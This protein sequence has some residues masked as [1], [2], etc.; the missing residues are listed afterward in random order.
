MNLN[1]TFFITF[2]LNKAKTNKHGLTPIW[3]RITVNSKRAECS[4]QKFVHAKHW[5]MEHNRVRTTCSD[6]TSINDYLDL[7][8]SEILRHYNILLTTQDVVTADDVKNSYKGIKETKK[9]FF[10]LFDQYLQHLVD[11]KE[12]NDLSEGRYKRFQVLLN[13]C[14]GFVKYKFRKADVILDEVKMNFIVEFEHYMRKT[15]KMGHNT[16]MK[17]AKDLKQIMKYGVMLEY[18]PSNPFDLFQCT[19]KKA[20]REFLNQEELDALYRKEFVIKRLAEVRDCYLFS[21]Y[22]G[23]AYSDA[24]ALGPDDVTLGIDGEKWIIRNR[25]KTDTTENV[26]LLPIPQEIIARY[27]NH[28]YCKAHNKLLPMNSNQRYNAYLKEVAALCGIRKNLTTHTARHTFA[29]TVL[30]VNDVPMETAM[31][32]LGHTDIRTTQIYGKIVQKKISN[33]MKK[34]KDRLAGNTTLRKNVG[35][36]VFK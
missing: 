14:K 3:L 24:A 1:Q 7:V 9:T 31:E 16:A 11:R 35:G 12:I 23:Y 29:T 33:D 19:Y 17:Y 21:C 4:V 22:T 8:R 20:K 28:P 32:L 6:A 18:I 15:D 13:K 36:N 10:Q 26:P 5:D 2:W 25:K 27:K 30:L 34:L